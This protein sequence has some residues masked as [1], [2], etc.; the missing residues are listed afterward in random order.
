MQGLQ[1]DSDH[2]KGLSTSTAVFGHKAI[3]GCEENSGRR[4]E[5]TLD[6][7][8]SQFA[9]VDVKAG[10]I[11]TEIL[12]KFIVD[13]AALAR[14]SLVRAIDWVDLLGRKLLL[15]VLFV[16]FVLND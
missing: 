7:N 1:S 3:V 11:V 16:E 5:Q 15:G 6:F 12:V 4:L 10:D 13:Q 2:L 8:E 9:G 14:R